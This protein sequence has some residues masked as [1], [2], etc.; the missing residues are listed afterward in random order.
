MYVN[1]GRVTLGVPVDH[2][3][4]VAEI[5]TL[6]GVPKNGDGEYTLAKICQAESINPNSKYKPVRSSDLFRTSTTYKANDGWCGLSGGIVGVRSLDNLIAMYAQPNNG[7]EHQLPEGGQWNQ[8]SRLRDFHGY[9]H[10]AVPYI[11]GFSVPSV[12][13]LEGSKPFLAQCMTLANET[14]DNVTL[15]ILPLKD[16]YFG[17]ALAK[18]GVIGTNLRMTN[19]QPISQTLFEIPEFDIRYVKEGEYTAYPFISQGVIGV[20]TTLGNAGEIRTLPYLQP[21]NISFIKSYITI[22][23]TAYFIASSQVSYNIVV[24]NAGGSGISLD[25]VVRVMYNDGRGPSDSLLAG[26]AQSILQKKTVP[27]NSLIEIS[28][29]ITGISAAVS[30]NPIFW[31]SFNSGQYVQS[32]LIMTSAPKTIN[33]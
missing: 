2:D 4:A 12:W 20:E 11:S 17:V 24:N 25:G 21:M 6:L 3:N 27:A 16:W 29:S 8:R 26:E 13:A 23:I 1:N 31:V 33:E 7:W 28:G 32:S 22:S 19:S 5:A 18:N 10:N 30:A 15:H 9:N 14:E